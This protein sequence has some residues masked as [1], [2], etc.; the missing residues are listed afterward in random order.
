M[1]HV[2]D[3]QAWHL[4][5]ADWINMR[6]NRKRNKFNFELHLSAGHV[7]VGH[8][9]DVAPFGHFFFVVGYFQIF[10]I[11]VVLTASGVGMVGIFWLYNAHMTN[12]TWKIRSKMFLTKSRITP[13]DLRP[14]G[15]PT[16]GVAS[17]F[18]M[19]W[20]GSNQDVFCSEWGVIMKS[21][22]LEGALGLRRRSHKTQ[23]GWYFALANAWVWNHRLAQAQDPKGY[24]FTALSGYVQCDLHPGRLSEALTLGGCF[25]Q[26]GHLRHWHWEA[27]SPREAIFITGATRLLHP[28]R[29]FHPE[30]LFLSSE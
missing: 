18:R 24:F 5:P 12:K 20:S 1:C 25:T 23:K 22:A 10:S 13:A 29:R 30:R 27:V 6:E 28:T 9:K 7:T 3:I 11:V 15:I 14:Q 26:G 2:A 16:F 19:Q 21:Q 8:S 17:S 4:L